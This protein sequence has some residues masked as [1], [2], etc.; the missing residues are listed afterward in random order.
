VAGGE[1]FPVG[2]SIVLVERAV[3]VPVRLVFVRVGVGN[4]ELAAAKRPVVAI[5]VAV[6]RGALRQRSLI[7]LPYVE[8]VLLGLGVC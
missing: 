8:P 1:V 4:V 5:A 6:L 3:R 7:C 2:R